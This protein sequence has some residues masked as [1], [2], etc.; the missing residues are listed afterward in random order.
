MKNIFWRISFL[1]LVLIGADCVLY[2]NNF[3]DAL[4]DARLF[5]YPDV[6]FDKITF[7]YAGDIWIAKK[8]GG[9]AVRLSTPRGEEMFP[10]FSPDGNYIAYTA[11]YDGNYDIYVIPVGGGTP[12]RLTWHGA[13]DRVIDW[14]PDGKRILFASGRESPRDRFN[15]LYTIDANGGLPVKL[16]VPYGEFASFSDDG[17]LLAYTPISRDFRTW[18]RYR[19]GMNPDIWVFDLEKLTATNITRHEANDSFPMWHGATIYF[20]SDRDDLKR[21]NIYAYDP[22]TGATRQITHFTD[23][24]IHFPSIGPSDIIFENGGKL[25]LLDL[26]TEE[27]KELMIKAITDE[28]TIRPRTHNVSGFTHNVTISPT[29]KRVVVEARGELFS[30]PAENGITFNLT[31]TSGSAERFPGWSPDGKWIAYFSDKTGEYELTIRPADGKGSEQTLT[32]LGPGFRYRPFWSP[33][34][35]KLAF[36]DQAMKIRVYNIETKK[37][38]FV[39]QQKWLYHGELNAFR[40]SWSPDSRW[41]AYAGDLDNRHSAIML[42][43]IDD[44]HRY[45][46]T[47]GFYNDESPVFDPDGKYLYYVSSRQFSP[48]YSE[49]DNTW[50][51]DNSMKIVAVALNTNVPPLLAERNDVEQPKEKSKNQPEKLKSE[52]IPA[53]QI[54]IQGFEFRGEQLPIQAGK[55]EMS[56]AAPG[57]IIYK[58]YSRSRDGSS[59]IMFFDVEKREEKTIISNV[60]FYEL[61][62]DHQKLLVQ[63]GNDYYIIDVRENQRAEKPVPTRELIATIEPREE[64]RQIFV[65]AWRLERDYFYDP[66]M[67]G[68]NW[69]EVRKTYEKLLDYAVT[70]WDVNFIIGEMIAELNASHTYRSGGDLESP[71]YMNVG[72]LGVDYDVE[73]GYYKFKKIISGAPWDI[74]VKSPLQNSGVKEGEFLIAVNGI[75]PDIS[76]EP[77]AI[78]QGLAEKVIVLTVNSNPTP[79]GSRD[80]IVKTLASEDRLRYLNWVESNRKLTEQLSDGLIGYIYVPDTSVNGQ[81]ELVR[82]FYAQIDKSGLIIDERFNSGGQIPDRFIELLNRPILNYWGVRDGKDWQWPPASCPGPKAMLINGWSGSGGDAFPFYF[83][84]TGIGPVIGTRT[85]GGLIGMTGVP[86]LIDNGSVTVPTFGIYSTNGQWIIEGY[87]VDPDIEVVDDPGTMAKGRDPQLEKAIEVVLEKIRTSP[88][89]QPQKPKYPDRSAKRKEPKE[90]R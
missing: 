15:Q 43:N 47:S 79:D 73:G 55:I 18:K 60:G 37:I 86:A 24:D 71:S 25:Y 26:K 23:Y 81:N 16:P 52:N 77:H 4:V 9:T 66:G 31:Q 83:K 67:H 14:T 82:Q 42:Y 6:S 84:K 64:W 53:T 20:L 88:I 72:Y 75:K 65:D 70:R 59:S 19:G 32:K 57:K 56:Y 3:P 33:D 62:A 40:V 45:Q 1:L 69:Q 78:F 34:S 63:Q 2:A 17:K 61:S 89:V 48:T 46:V 10:K 58:R 51:Y 28:P 80:I 8:E 87:G 36:I 50:I 30:V 5:R 29:G 22:K 49:M 85:W 35:K 68:V 44:G 12:N 38:I 27:T 90:N 11:N 21:A 54:D 41:I 13:V 76:K 39:D 7:V 74:E